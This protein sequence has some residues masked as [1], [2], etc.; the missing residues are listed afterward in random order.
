MTGTSIHHP[1]KTAHQP[2]GKSGLALP[3]DRMTKRRR[4]GDTDC[5]PAP[6]QRATGQV[7]QML[8]VCFGAWFF[9]P[10]FISGS[11]FMSISHVH[12]HIC[13]RLLRF[14]SGETK[15]NEKR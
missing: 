1:S 9:M 2:A 13:R 4:D 12:A 3:S 8:Y 5:Y 10:T 6:T 15:R 14:T 7:V 11:Y